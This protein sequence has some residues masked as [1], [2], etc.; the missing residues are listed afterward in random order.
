M[1][2]IEQDAKIL[3]CV[4]LLLTMI[5]LAAKLYASQAFVLCLLLITWTY[6]TPEAASWGILG[7]CQ[8]LGFGKP[9]HKLANFFVVNVIMQ[10]AH[11]IPCH[12]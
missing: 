2:V 5:K 6:E 8:N 9:F 7:I 12:S 4:L 3:F 11:V 10:I 1:S